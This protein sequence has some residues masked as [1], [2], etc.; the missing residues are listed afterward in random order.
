MWNIIERYI[1][2]AS[3]Y[4]ADIDFLIILITI[5]VGAWFILSEVLL[6]YFI[7]RYS[8]KRNPRAQYITGE[9]ESEKKWIKTPHKLI[10]S[11]KTII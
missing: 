1:P 7:I 11:S 5:I 2:N 4:G 6:F 3:S 8:R 9:E 10:L